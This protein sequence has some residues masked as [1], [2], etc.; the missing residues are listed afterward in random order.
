M[1]MAVDQLAAAR[2]SLSGGFA[3]QAVS[4]GYY[5]ML[6]A[7]RAA[8]SEEDL[9]A[10]THGGTW[11]LFQQTFVDLGR[12]DRSLFDDA[13]KTQQD[14]EGADYDAVRAPV[15]RA[16]EIVEVAERFVAAVLKLVV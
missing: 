7:S 3:F 16:E 5:A 15:E 6:Y 10:K 12:F 4:S 11:N 2:A 9:Y 8:L 1:A 13:R 14:R